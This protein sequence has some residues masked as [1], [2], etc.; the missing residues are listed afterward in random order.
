MATVVGVLLWA[1]H[2]EAHGWRVIA[3]QI[4]VAIGSCVLLTNAFF[5]NVKIIPFTGEMVAEKRNLAIV[6]LKYVAA[7]VPWVLAVQNVEPWIEASASHMVMAILIVGVTH[8]AMQA[9]HRKL[10]SDHL[11][12]PD[13]DEDQHRLFQTLGLRY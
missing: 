10:L 3:G 13:L 8:V 12:V 1:S 6:L 2:T 5:L 4:L 11:S 7:F 9:I